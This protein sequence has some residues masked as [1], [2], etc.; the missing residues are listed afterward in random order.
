MVMPKRLYEVL[1]LF[2]LYLVIMFFLNYIF[3][4]LIMAKVALI[5]LIIGAFL[6]IAAE[7]YSTIYFGSQIFLK[8]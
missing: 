8:L 3:A 6:I 4:A 5:P 2:V 7:A 1:A